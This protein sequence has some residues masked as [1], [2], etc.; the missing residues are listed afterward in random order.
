MVW[1][2]TGQEE[3]P[4][5]VTE[6]WGN[7]GDLNSLAMYSALEPLA[8]DGRNGGVLLPEAAMVGGLPQP[9]VETS[10][11]LL[12]ERHQ[13]NFGARLRFELQPTRQRLPAAHIFVELILAGDEHCQ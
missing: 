4:G 6:W 12:L 9:G 1:T 7:E 13:G 5:P 3:F 8:N 11:V 10:L 2:Y